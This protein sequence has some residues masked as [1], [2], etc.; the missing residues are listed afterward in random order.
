M[1]LYNIPEAVRPSRKF[2]RTI[3]ELI[4]DN[5]TEKAIAVILDGLRATKKYWSPIAKQFVEEP[6]HRTR[7]D[8]A[9]TIIAYHEGTPVQRV[10]AVTESFESLRDAI[11]AATHS[12]EAQRILKELDLA[13]PE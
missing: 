4:A 2:R 3:N 6:D 5:E 9:K 13:S 7:L 12:E 1:E 10:V 8:S 11:E